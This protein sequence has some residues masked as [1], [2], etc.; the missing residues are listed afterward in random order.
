[1]KI[2]FRWNLIDQIAAPVLVLDQLGA[3]QYLNDDACAL[4]DFAD[5]EN[6]IGQ[7]FIHN[8]SN[9]DQTLYQEILAVVSNGGQVEDQELFLCAQDGSVFSGYLTGRSLENTSE[10]Q[11]CSIWTIRLT[12]VIDDNLTALSQQQEVEDLQW[13]ADQG[14]ILLSLDDWSE[15]LDQGSRA[16][17]EKLGDC[18]VVSLT[19]IDENTLKMEQIHGIENRLINRVWKMIGRDFHNRV[20]PIDDRFREVYGKRKLYQH[21]GGLEDFAIS[22]VPEKISRKLSQMVGLKNIYAIGLEGNQA[23]LGC[24]YIFTFGS[25]KPINGELVE[26][27][28]FQVALALEKS[29]YS[30][31]LELSEEQF[32]TIFEFAPD[33]YFISDLK[34]NFI[35]GNRASERI[36]GYSRQ[37][38]IGKNFLKVGLISKAQLPLVAKLLAEGV[39]G[40]PT[41]PTEFDLSKKDGSVANLE[42][43]SYPVMLGEKAV[44]LG[45][46]RDITDRK[47]NEEKLNYAYESL[48]RVLEGIDA[49]VYVADIETYELLYMNKRMIE[50]Y[51]GNFVGKLC[52]Q[53]FR[54]SN[55]PCPECSNSHLVNNMGEP[56][57]VYVWDGQNKKNHQWYRNYDRAIYWIDQRL[58]RLQIAVD[59]TSNKLAGNYL[60]QS[61]QR[62]RK[63]FETSHNALMTISPPDWRFSSGNPAM[64]KVFGLENEKQ[65]VELQPWQLSPEYQPDGQL[66]GGKAQEMIRIAVDKG[67]NFFHW[68]HKKITG[69]EFPA[70]VQLT[71]VDTND[72]YFLQATVR[73]ITDEIRA[74][75]KLNQ[76]M[77]DLALLND[78]NVG[79]NQGKDLDEITAHVSRETERLFSSRS[80]TVYLLSD[81]GKFL[82]VNLFNEK[83]SLLN[84]IEE[85]LGLTMPEQLEIPV[86]A[87]GIFQKLLTSGEVKILSTKEEVLELVIEYLNSTFLSERMRKGLRKMIPAIYRLID[88]KSIIIAPLISEGKP[89]GFIDMSSSQVFSDDEKSRFVTIADQLSGII[90]K[91]RA[92]KERLEKLTELEIIYNTVVDGSRLESVDEICQHLAATIQDVNPDCYVMVTLYDP[93]VKAIRV[94]ALTGIGNKAEGLFKLIGKNPEDILIDT[95]NNNI[96]PE[97]NEIFTSGTLKLVP[98]GMYDLSR[99]TIPRAVCKS[100]ERFMGVGEIYIAGFGLEND[101][102]G[103]LI[104]FVK[105]G[106]KVRYPEAIETIANHF[107]ILFG[108]RQ[109][110]S[111][112]INRQDQLV[113]LRDVG[114]DIAAELDLNELLHSLAE[115]SKNIVNASASGFSIVNQE[116]NI[117]EYLGYTGFDE[118]PDDTDLKIGEGLSGKVWETRETIIVENYV[119]WEG[120]S[121]PWVPVSNYYLAGIPV[122]W[123]DEFL[124]VLEI[125]LEIGDYLTASDIEMLEL[126]AAQAAIA[127]KNARLFNDERLRRT[128]ADT[129]REVGVLINKLVDRP[130]LMD[131]ILTSLQKVVPYSSAS[132]QLVKGSE[133]VIEAYLGHKPQNA[134][135]GT[136]Y[137]IQEN[138]A[139]RQILIEGKNIILD[140]ETDVENF[141]EGPNLDKVKSWLGVPLE[142]KGNR[143]G[144][145]TLDHISP[146]QFNSRDA[147]LV[148][149]FAAQAVVALE[150]NRLFDEIRRRTKEIEAVYDSALS[151]TKELQP[152]MLF[153][154]LFQQIDPLFSPDAYILALY[155]QNTDMISIAY[156]T[157]S[158]VRQS[159]AETL[160]ISTEEKNS[161]LGWIV[162]KKTPLLIGNVET[163]SIPIQPMQK[164]RVVRS[165]LGVPIL[166]G[167]R[168]TGAM[169]VQSYQPNVYSKDD[170]RLIQLLANQVAIALENSRL[171]DDAQRRLTRLSSLREIDQAI[172]GGTDLEP[173]M[174]VLVNQLI[175]TLG[176][177]AACVLAYRPSSQMLE[178]VDAK[179][180]RGKSLH[181]TALKLGSGLAGKAALEQNLVFI[182]DLKKQ[183]TSFQQSPLFRKEDFVTYVAQPLITKGG[184]VGVLEVFHRT[185]LTPDP[186]WFTFLDAISRLA[187]IAIDRLNLYEN[188][189]KSNI[190]LTQ[191]YEATI[192]GWAKA[193]ELRDGE[194]EGH[195]RRV[196]ALTMN[197]AR[198]MGVSEQELVH[199]RRGALLHDI[200]KMA[201]PDEILLKTGKLSD[202]EWLVM[203]KHPIYAFEMLS[204]IE[205][206]KQA[207]DIPTCHHER[208]DGSGYPAGLAGENIPLQARIFAV[209][210]VWDALQADRPYRKAWSEEKTIQYLIDQSEKE[211]DPQVV[212][213]FLDLIGKG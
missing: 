204:K 175:Y 136:K 183:S 182:P 65:F 127:I 111:E 157:E 79:A 83:R 63:L 105:E 158:G 98:D 113:A 128:E 170:Q 14:R 57:D 58:V 53:I 21:P 129:L 66:S 147:D 193:I 188:L 117:L 2:D 207:L 174:D 185:A 41:G 89:F 135:V 104:L 88:I 62:Y 43:S 31:E 74:E 142:S 35:N 211:F 86:N 54:D 153:E 159:E 40:K 161:L 130:E 34:G 95:H 124:A 176:V 212:I 208:W 122:C 60:E 84:Q 70:T 144:I 72:S 138:D 164:G 201:I 67:S 109:V 22:Q 152:E 99:R 107:A 179:G 55:T 29:K 11:E 56:G 103:G 156:A 82:Y 189:E 139:A 16:L 140:N 90:Q 184:L 173:T 36:T 110:Q 148:K 149:D 93:E 32:Q 178:Y 46:A 20:F 50:D 168:I 30:Q 85:L 169:V 196:E 115:K 38:L 47:Q 37:E 191:A 44:V 213:E 4:L 194:T 33:G 123:G 91:N 45:I 24:F 87:D 160:L 97:L 131:M 195:S 59:I 116:R 151:L 143:I 186:E 78:L 199:M 108:R 68:T 26:S 106:K 172:S 119:E 180:F 167:D 75:E 80:T 51:G 15:I 203:K 133:I 190:E 125:A 177:D 73:D 114:L 10:N 19:K 76:Q 92:E 126:F 1:M 18:Y 5:K 112:I 181:H 52:H 100:A 209:V 118:L 166:I 48:T 28:T 154:N 137:K 200:G 155:D 6:I 9:D 205:Y 162:R 77:G 121:E 198:K 61:E 71:R 134:I 146:K 145:L 3:I 210:D 206:L 132:V 150:N 12:P 141:L 23:V 96:D 102:S 94:K 187:A 202:E 17:Q 171:F 165:L 163:D 49:H 27:F 13:L 42:I 192:E 8:I 197:L 120:R 39:S 7:D 81:D 69:E 64:I 25:G 101:S